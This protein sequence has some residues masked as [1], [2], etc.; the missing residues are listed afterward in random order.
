MWSQ[1][2]TLILLLIIAT[3]LQAC[4]DGASGAKSSVYSA[5][6]I[7]GL[8]FDS[9]VKF[10]E[11]SV[12]TLTG[13]TVGT[14]T[15]D[16]SGHF[17]VSVIAES[18]PLII[19]VSNG[20]YIE[21][22]TNKTIP[23]SD[24]RMMVMINYQ[25][26]ENQLISVTGLTTIAVG[27][28]DYSI[29]QKISASEAINSANTTISN[30]FGVDVV[31]VQP[32]N[33]IGYIDDGS[34][35][36][37][38]GT[39][40]AA[41]SA[42]MADVLLKN[43]YDI[44][45]QPNTKFTSIGFINSAYSDIS[46]DG[47]L[48]G[49]SAFG[50]D[51][52]G[53]V[54]I[55]ENT[56]RNGLAQG[57][58]LAA[59]NDI[60]LL[61]DYDKVRAKAAAF[62][63]SSSP[64]FN[65]APIIPLETDKPIINN[66][67]FQAGDVVS[68]TFNVSFDVSDLYGLESLVLKFGGTEYLISNFENPSTAI[69]TVV[70]DDGEYVVNIKA[71]SQG[72]AEIEMNRAVVVENSNMTFSNITPA[73]NASVWGDFKFSAVVTHPAGVKRVYF[74]VDDSIHLAGGS[75]NT[76][77]VGI[78]TTLFQDGVHTLKV[79]AV[80]NLDKVDEFVL[81]FNIN[82]TSPVVTWDLLDDSYIE[83]NYT[84]SASVNDTSTQGTVD[85]Y[86]D[87]E[88]LESYSEFGSISHVLDTTAYVDGQYSL[89]I[90]A[91]DVDGNPVTVSKSIYIDN[92]KPVVWMNTV[93]GITVDTYFSLSFG[94]SDANGFGNTSH[95][96]FI[97]NELYSY[98]TNTSLTREINP[99]NRPNGWHVIK[100]TVIDASGKDSSVSINVNFQAH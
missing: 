62:N 36:Y 20:T 31:N 4:S 43:N 44:D 61:P 87:N 22:F 71:I 58:L 34:K 52:F 15:T 54:D 89:R 75:D 57:L 83:G 90:D 100:L 28:A 32:V 53:T 25:E 64:I 68:G 2:H 63:N 59:A 12:K 77:T 79:K 85:L 78:D 93:S 60:F 97:D 88:L 95:E 23:L 30:W 16:I 26:G 80:N 50:N 1:L 8:A 37:E 11:V 40:T 74:H 66:L 5:G 27:L 9:E 47:V 38:Y 72:G 41:I 6:M 65:G 86:I 46:H 48:D 82:N 99:F 33:V 7:E 55:D 17:S 76:F 91:M 24:S 39:V 70:M 3:S 56:Y 73:N 35:S 96:V 81:K 10:A 42:Y 13:E 51:Q 84:I 14:A 21:E 67:S 29:S 45:F 69:N 98:V 94:Y 18:Q 49:V 19:I 92:T